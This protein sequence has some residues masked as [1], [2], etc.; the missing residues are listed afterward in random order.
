MQLNTQ[1]FPRLTLG[2]QSRADPDVELLNTTFLPHSRGSAAFLAN[3]PLL[4]H[5]RILPL[6][7][8]TV[9][10]PSYPS[11]LLPLHPYLGSF[12]E[13]KL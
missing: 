3:L 7:P 2:D 11:M 4:S 8:L 1:L 12:P 5:H 13:T 10:C 9:S 6:P